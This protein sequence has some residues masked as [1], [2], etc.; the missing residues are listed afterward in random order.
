MTRPA[1]DT[2]L[3]I[4]GASGFLGRSL[5]RRLSLGPERT[6]SCLSRHPAQLEPTLPSPSNWRWIRG[7][8]TDAASYA[9]AL[10]PADTVLHMAA[11]TGKERPGVFTEVNVEGTR[12]LV[13]SAA[14]AGVSRFIFVSSIAAKFPDKRHYPYAHSKLEAERI[15]KS[16]GLGWVIIRPT[17]VFGAG[18]P[19]LR[20]LIKLVKGPVGVIFGSG[21]VR[22]QPIDVDDVADILM[23]VCDQTELA[24]QTIEVGGPDVLSFEDLLRRIRGRVS[25]RSGGVVHIPLA[26]LRTL[27]AA[28]EP[29]LLPLLPFGAGQLAAFANDSTADRHPLVETCL[30]RMKTIDTMLDVVASSHG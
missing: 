16:S 20:G 7:E 23:H 13:E 3:F 18:S 29:A 14:D 11:A 25:K 4:T 6:V 1:P 30:P 26:P 22:V 19:V 28:L 5:L 10:K 8:L 24:E 2:S 17:L 21:V 12:Q 27:L 9:P 15:V